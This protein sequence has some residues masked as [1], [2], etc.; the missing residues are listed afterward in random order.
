MNSTQAGVDVAKS[1]FEVAL[2]DT[3]GSVRE[4][5]RLSRER[6]RRFFATRDFP[7][8]P[9]RTMRPSKGLRYHCSRPRSSALRLHLL[10]EESRCVCQTPSVPRFGWEAIPFLNRLGEPAIELRS[11]TRPGFPREPTSEEATLGKH[12]VARRRTLHEVQ[13][14]SLPTV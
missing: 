8:W 9:K 3:P 12:E 7:S 1:V 11:H 13:V 5:H 4:R 10:R 2:S 6:F 14:A